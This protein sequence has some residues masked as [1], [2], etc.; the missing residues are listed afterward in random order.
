MF[1]SVCIERSL[2]IDTLNIM[3]LESS[4]YFWWYACFGDRIVLLKKMASGDFRSAFSEVIEGQN[5][6]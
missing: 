4:T 5:C 1:V 6:I 2:M 3:G